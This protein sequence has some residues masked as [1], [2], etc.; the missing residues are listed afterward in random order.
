MQVCGA[1][2]ELA[3][4]GG[5]SQ[6]STVLGIFTLH[7]F[8]A[9][10]PL[11]S[12]GFL[13]DA[14]SEQ[15][16]SLPSSSFCLTTTVLRHHSSSLL[17][18]SQPSGCARRSRHNIP[19][20]TTAVMLYCF[21]TLACLMLISPCGVHLSAKG[22]DAGYIFSEWEM[23]PELCDSFSRFTHIHRHCLRRHCCCRCHYQ[24]CHC[25]HCSCLL[26]V[27][28]YCLLLLVAV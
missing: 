16:C 12:I 28:A 25:C 13:A 11:A 15:F 26:L 6:L 19:V 27:A 5:T 20:W 23:T 18:R 24:C 9:L 7:V 4:T 3:R 22:Y 10:A 17:P 1:L 14:I 21:A 2:V 8:S